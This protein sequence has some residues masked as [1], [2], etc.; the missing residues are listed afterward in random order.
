[1]KTTKIKASIRTMD[2]NETHWYY[3]Y[4]LANGSNQ[5]VRKI[6]YNA[7]WSQIEE[8]WV[9]QKETS[10]FSEEATDEW[11]LFTKAKEIDSAW[12]EIL[13]WAYQPNARKV[14]VRKR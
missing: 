9:F 14:N 13:D 10:G 2:K 11:V 7:Y 12:E 1:M 4:V 6:I 3:G 5:I 8:A